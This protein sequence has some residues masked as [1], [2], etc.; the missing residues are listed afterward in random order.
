MEISQLIKE[1]RAVLFD[2]DGIII[3][4]DSL[5]DEAKRRAVSFCGV[6]VGDAEWSEI[7]HFTSAQIY[8][9]L[10]KKHS[11]IRLTEEEFVVEKSRIFV[12]IA[13]HKMKAITGAFEF[14]AYLKGKSIRTALVTAS[15]KDTLGIVASKFDLDKYFDII[16]TREDVEKAKPDPEAYLKAARLLGVEPKNSLVLEDSV[17]GVQS[18]KAAGCLVIGRSDT[19][20]GNILLEAGADAVFKDYNELY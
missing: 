10:C 4:S 15:R 19:V 2:M 3:D 9:L 20:S 11:E 14:V 13:P 1:A 5:H 6:Q 18:G 7:R 12:E 8:Q 16:L 17:P